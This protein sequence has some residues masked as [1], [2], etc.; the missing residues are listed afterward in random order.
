MP[1][2]SLQGRPRTFTA[3]LVRDDDGRVTRIVG[4]LDGGW[5]DEDVAAAMAA[6]FDE[7]DRCGGCGHPLSQTTDP[8]SQLLWESEPIRCQA[9]A[10]SARA[11]DGFEGKNRAG[12]MVRTWL[13]DREG[14]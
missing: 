9:C 6:D 13:D 3:D 14:G 1:L 11:A 2:S 12:L 5:T 4:Q 8:D 7:R 10:A